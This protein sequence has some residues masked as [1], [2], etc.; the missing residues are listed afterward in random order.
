LN[1]IDLVNQIW[2]L[3]KEHCFK[4][5]EFSLYFH[6]LDVS[7]SLGW[8]NPFKQGNLVI[9]ATIGVSEPVL[10][11]SRQKLAD[12][13]LI[14][15][16]S[17]KVKGQVTEYNLKDLG[18]RKLYQSK[19]LSSTLSNT[20]SDT[21]VVPQ[22][23]DINKQEVNKNYINIQGEVIFEIHK[24][25]ECHMGLQKPNWQRLYPL[26]NIT[27]TLDDFLLKKAFETFNDKE[28]FK[29]SFAKELKFVQAKN[30]KEKSFG[31]KEKVIGKA[32]SLMEQDQR[33]KELENDQYSKV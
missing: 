21:K 14:N 33:L 26:A 2:I 13:G 4:P 31:K 6:L 30:E 7:N 17:G 15:F 28:H 32:Q 23:H 18:I 5:S 22:V 29:N 19:H 24:W 16:K 1:Y 11:R 8:K 20:P 27:N 12:S 3:N 9:C 25:F 10:Q